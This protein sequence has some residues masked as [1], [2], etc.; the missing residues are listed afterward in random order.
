MP[1]NDNRQTIES[2]EFSHLVQCNLIKAAFDP[3]DR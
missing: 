3:R 1:E 2:P